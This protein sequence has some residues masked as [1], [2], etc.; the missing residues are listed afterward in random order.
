MSQTH[1]KVEMSESSKKLVPATSQETARRVRDK[2]D[3]RILSNI[4]DL[5]HATPEKLTEWIAAELGP[6]FDVFKQAFINQ[7]ID[8]GCVSFLNESHLKEMVP[9][10]TIGDRLHLL[11]V[12]DKFVR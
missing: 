12:R 6:R 10:S 5:V 3:E 1:S 8:G 4:D 7:K 2:R 9:D 11:T